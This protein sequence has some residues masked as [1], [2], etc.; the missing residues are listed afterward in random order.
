L[1]ELLVVMAIVGILAALLLM[2]VTGVKQ[3]SQETVCLSNLRQ[4]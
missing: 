1:I 2:A 3:R 4:I